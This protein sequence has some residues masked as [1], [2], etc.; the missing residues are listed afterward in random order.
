VVKDSPVQR[1]SESVPAQLQVPNLE[2]LPLD[3]R[4]AEARRLIGQEAMRPFDLSEG[5]LFR[6]CLLRLEEEDHVFLLTMHHIISDGWST[7]IVFR[8]LTTLYE[9]FAANKSSRLPELTIQYAD[10]SVWQREWLQGGVLEKQLSYWKK[11]LA[12]APPLLEL[13]IGKPRPTIQTQ[14]GAHQSVKLPRELWEELKNL[15]QREGVTPYMLLLAAFQVLL[16]IYARR[17]DIVV[18]S[19]I[20]GR[21]RTEIEGLVGFFVN[22][23]VLR[24]NLSGNPRFRE[25]LERVR[26]VCLEAY[27]HQDL[28]FEKL[29]EE[30]QP[31][32][33][34]SYSP[35]FQVLFA[36]QNAPASAFE[37]E[38]LKLTAFGFDDNTTRFDL[39]AHL[40]ERSDSLICSFV[41]N[42]DLFDAATVAQ[43]ATHYRRLLES[44]VAGPEEH[45]SELELLTEAEREKIL[46][47][48][49]ATEA[50]YPRDKTVTELF[51]EQVER[52]PEA[53]AVVFNEEQVSYRELNERANQLAHYLQSRGVGPDTLVGLCLNKSVEMIV[54]MLATLKA[55]GAYL[56]MDPNYP[57]ERLRFMVEDSG[58]AYLVSTESLV[59]SV[60][61]KVATTI[62]LDAEWLEIK[63]QSQSTPDSKCTPSSLIYC[64]YTSGS[65]G[66]PKGVLLEHRNV[67]RLL[68]NER[69]L[70]NFGEQDVWTMF[71]SYCFDFSV[72]EMY[73]ALLYGGKV[74]I[75]AEPVMKDPSLFLELLAEQKVTVLNQT[76]TAFYNLAQ[77]ALRS[78][79]ALSLRYVIFG[80]EAL[81][82]VQ[83][84]EWKEAYPE[85]KL[86]NMYGITET[87]VHVTYKEITDQDIAENR[88]N[89]GRPIPTTTTYVMDGQLRLQPVG[90]IGEICVGGEG[91][92]RGYLGREDL[93][94]QKFVANPY[95]PQER[96]Y[97]SGDFGKLLPDGELIYIG[98]IDDQVQIRGFRVEP[99]EIKSHLLEHP[100]VAEAE[101]IARESKSESVELIAYV[102]PR[103]EISLTALRN[104]LAETLPFYMVPTAFVMLEA[105]PLTAN[106]KVDRQA[107]PDPDETRPEIEATF[108]APRTANEEVLTKIWGEILGLDQVGVFDNFFELGGHSL[109]ATQ[110]VSRINDMFE[111]RVSLRAFFEQPT[112][113]GLADSMISADQLHQETVPAIRRLPRA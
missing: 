53:V 42:T 80:G 109:L 55:G 77:E 99:G 48:W 1:I 83:L 69:Q 104:H 96:L 94:R 8:E 28:P 12:S 86:I 103:A 21:N 98:R 6:A 26:E 95:R 85:T 88:S 68:I 25:L 92:G 10:Y 75:V 40:W 7:D 51:S 38:G 16:S 19:P 66:Q 93:T 4:E 35:V 36:L 15:A 63:A 47:E 46:V 52:T 84:K 41:Y 91:V 101:V 107:L 100:L 31:G 102:V 39:E 5:P 22:S 3:E 59:G 27:A 79:P 105:L 56:P 64:I 32:R 97:R 60:P 78:G 24:V 33:N 73:G 87:T 29:V 58:M 13:S 70:F 34:F 89:I 44:V 11:Q 62:L 67:V 76:P 82:P 72:W 61:Q 74:V 45:I 54:A 110:V 43:L 37:L 112:V 106:G 57:R 50:G 2:Y 30:L 90:V 71:H 23:L 81:H 65:T 17:E 14:N 113:A 108:V 9:S 20:A 111:V 18:G 49:N